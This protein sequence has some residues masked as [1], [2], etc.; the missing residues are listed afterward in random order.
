M[1]N[2]ELINYLTRLYIGELLDFIEIR[3]FLK[4]SWIAAF[5]A[6]SHSL[7]LS[8]RYR[9]SLVISLWMMDDR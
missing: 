8:L 3:G 5:S 9:L 4:F 2:D 1:S 7:S 6:F